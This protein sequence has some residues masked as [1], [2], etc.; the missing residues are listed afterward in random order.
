M[1]LFLGRHQAHSKQPILKT[2]CQAEAMMILQ[3]MTLTMLSMAVPETTHSQAWVA[4]MNFMA[5]MMMISSMVV[6][7]MI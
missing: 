4:M 2:L 1:C 5:A 3:G 7:A 6:M